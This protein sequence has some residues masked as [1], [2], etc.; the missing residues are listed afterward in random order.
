LDMKAP[1]SGRCPA[2]MLSRAS[3]L[4]YGRLLD[5]F[6]EVIDR[7]GELQAESPAAPLETGA[8]FR[9]GGLLSIADHYGQHVPGHRSKGGITSLP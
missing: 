5:P 9:E 2:G 4:V 1:A 6:Y 3:S 7:V 8:I